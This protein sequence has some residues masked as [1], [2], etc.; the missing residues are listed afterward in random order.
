M[1]EVLKKMAWS[2]DA[3]ARG[4][5][6]TTTSDGDVIDDE[7]ANIASPKGKHCL[8]GNIVLKENARLKDVKISP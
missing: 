3:L 5:H 8:E 4:R 6:P 2:F 1:D 7:K